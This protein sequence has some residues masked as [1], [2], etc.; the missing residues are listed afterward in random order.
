MSLS[1]IELREPATACGPS[2]RICSRSRA[3]AASDCC[4]AFAILSSDIRLR[5]ISRREGYKQRDAIAR[6]ARVSAL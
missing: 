3:K 1:G 5:S 6:T 4:M 2:L